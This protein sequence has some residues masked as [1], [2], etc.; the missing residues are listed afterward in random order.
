MKVVFGKDDVLDI[1]GQI[2]LSFDK[3][4]EA[5]QDPD[6]D[7]SYCGTMQGKESV[8]VLVYSTEWLHVGSQGWLPLYP[9]E[10]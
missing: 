4:D 2:F 1:V 6:I 5:V 8:L 10:I 9:T 3:P 7:G